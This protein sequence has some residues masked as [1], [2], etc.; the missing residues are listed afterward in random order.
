MSAEL[1]VPQLG[2]SITEAVVGKWNKNVGDSVAADEPVV[3][4]N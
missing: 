4:L 3:V 1:R 2:E